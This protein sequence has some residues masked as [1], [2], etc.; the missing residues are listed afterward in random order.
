MGKIQEFFYFM[1]HFTEFSTLIC[2]Y[3]L[4][5]AAFIF[6]K[7]YP[8]SKNKF[9]FKLSYSVVSFHTRSFS[10]DFITIYLKLQ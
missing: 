3:L 5:R 10:K 2:V 4:A 9:A 7:N 8:C 1:R 6:N